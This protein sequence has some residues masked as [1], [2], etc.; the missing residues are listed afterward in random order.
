MPSTKDLKNRLDQELQRPSTLRL[1]LIFSEGED[2]FAVIRAC[3]LIRQ[4]AQQWGA[5]RGVL[6]YGGQDYDVVDEED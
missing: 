6:S 3:G 1:E 4:E 5:V 2:A